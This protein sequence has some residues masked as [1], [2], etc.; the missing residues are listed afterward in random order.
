MPCQSDE[1]SAQG[2]REPGP[3]T[4]PRRRRNAG[5]GSDKSDAE[6]EDGDDDQYLDQPFS[7]EP[8]AEKGKRR[9]ELPVL[10]TV[11]TWDTG[12][13]AQFEDSDIKYQLELAPRNLMHESGII[14]LPGHKENKSES[15]IRPW[16][17]Q[18]E[19]VTYKFLRRQVYCLLV[20][21]A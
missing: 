19:S 10:T 1:E 5:A 18:E 14:K 15:I 21:L 11:R 20:S 2:P 3:V 7:P 4:P 17:V 16:N 6:I 9:L 12:I 8:N 13:S